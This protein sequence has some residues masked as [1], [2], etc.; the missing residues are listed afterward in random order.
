MGGG[1]PRPPPALPACMDPGSTP[2]AAPQAREA[3]APWEEEGAAG[4]EVVE[5]NAFIVADGGLFWAPRGP[6]LELFPSASA[7]AAPGPERR[8]AAAEE[9]EEEGGAFV[10][11]GVR[12]LPVSPPPSAAAPTGPRCCCCAAMS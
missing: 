9:E 10:F 4:D 3:P 12:A 5:A 11:F 8:A 2:A 1:P 6:S 7:A